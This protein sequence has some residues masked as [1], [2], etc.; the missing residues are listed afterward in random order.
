MI[1]F[2]TSIELNKTGP[3]CLLREELLCIFPVVNLLMSPSNSIKAMAS[4]FLSMVDG[5]IVDFVS[6]H[7]SGE[8]A[9]TMWN[10][11]GP[12]SS[13]L[14]RLLHHLLFE[15]IPWPLSLFKFY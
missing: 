6:S 7:P 12:H 15:V 11:V 1:S 13:A 2:L 5:L 10:S 3:T 4:N 8:N 9:C 14:L